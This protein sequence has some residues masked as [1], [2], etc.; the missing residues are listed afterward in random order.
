MRLSRLP[1][2]FMVCNE[3]LEL[4]VSDDLYLLA[5]GPVSGRKN[6]HKKRLKAKI[7]EI[8]SPGR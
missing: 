3:N 4:G 7:Q 8:I 2:G 6:P 5:L 1:S